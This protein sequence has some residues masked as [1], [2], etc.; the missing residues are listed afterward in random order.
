MSSQQ[1]L[2]GCQTTPAAVCNARK[3]LDAAFL[4]CDCWRLASLLV[5]YMPLG[6]RAGVLK[7]PPI[8]KNKRLLGCTCACKRQ[9]DVH[10]T[11]ATAQ[12]SGPWRS[13]CRRL[14]SS[15]G[16]RDYPPWGVDPEAR[17]FRPPVG[18]RHAGSAD[19]PERPRGAPALR[20]ARTACS[21][22][23]TRSAAKTSRDLRWHQGENDPQSRGWKASRHARPGR[24]L[25]V[26]RL[27]PAATRTIRFAVVDRYT[28][29]V[30]T[31]TTLTLKRVAGQAQRITFREADTLDDWLASATTTTGGGAGAG[32]VAATEP[33]P[34]D[35]STALRGLAPLRLAPRARTGLRLPGDG[36][37]R[38]RRA[39]RQ[40][41]REPRASS[42]LP[43]VGQGLGPGRRDGRPP[44]PP[45]GTR[46]LWA[47]R[48]RTRRASAARRCAE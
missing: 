24:P 23:A 15:A 26:C 40:K 32:L 30:E 25:V 39:R 6:L 31:F 4:A 16:G 5:C 36:R 35:L 45:H 47:S 28:G 33:P 44:E 7:T 13:S 43:A 34:R 20:H 41:P 8:A 27:L 48:R 1:V 10:C 14:P 3:R 18:G 12:G 19:G 37:T 17:G 21:R 42:R 2:H 11:S 38:L 29:S 46:W 9:G 22:R